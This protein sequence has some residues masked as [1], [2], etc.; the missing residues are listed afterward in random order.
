MQRYLDPLID[1]MFADSSKV[2]EALQLLVETD[3]EAIKE[4]MEFQIN[5]TMR[6]YQFL[7]EETTS[8]LKLVIKI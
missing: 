3:K 4:T 7:C 1:S 5:S 8:H 2:K 6:N